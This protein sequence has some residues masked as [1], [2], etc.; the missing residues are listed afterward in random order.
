VD[1]SYRTRFAFGGGFKMLVER[2]S[3]SV[4]I[5]TGFG[6]TPWSAGFG[7]QF[8]RG[9]R[10]CG[11]SPSSGCACHSAGLG[12]Y[13]LDQLIAAG[14]NWASGLVQSKLPTSA[15]VPPQYATT[16][17]VATSIMNSWIPWV[18]GGIIVYKL[19]K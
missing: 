6:G 15:A 18:V 9:L 1:H 4:P 11:C 17:T 19:I 14:F 7:T 8:N 10:G 16:G 2:K 12:D 5:Y 13:S 3:L